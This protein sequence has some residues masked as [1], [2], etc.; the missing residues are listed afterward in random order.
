MAEE[1]HTGHRA[2]LRKTY[3]AHGAEGFLDHQFLELLLTY[4]LPRKDTNALAHALLQRFGSLESVVTAEVSQLMLVGG[5]GESAAIFLRMQGDL[6]R[7]LLLSRAANAKGDVRIN[8]PDAAARYA[9]AL[10]LLESYECVAVVC[11]NAKLIVTASETLQRGSL[12]EAQ[13]YPRN[14][15]EVALLRRAHGV[16]LIHNHPSGDP[17]PSQEDAKATESVRTALECVGV[18]LLDHMIV[19]GRN[20]YSFSANAVIDTAGKESAALTLEAFQSRREARA[21]LLEKVMEPY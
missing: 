8:T 2:R 14:I 16:L 19:G 18:R 21:P 12:S 5:V 17:T 4:A 13:I 1:T 10:L 15:A 11:V 7:R 20:A 3:A 6:F 9:V